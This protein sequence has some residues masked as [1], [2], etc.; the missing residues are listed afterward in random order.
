MTKN[1]RVITSESEPSELVSHES[2]D[3]QPNLSLI[4]TQTSDVGLSVPSLA[5]AAAIV[6][7]LEKIRIANGNRLRILTAPTDKA[8]DDGICRGLGLP[9]FHPM[10]VMLQSTIADIQVSEAMAVKVLEKEVKSHP[11]G[12]WIQKTK[13]VGLKQA[14]RLLSAIGDPY[15]NSST[16]QPRTVSSLWA[17]CGL[18][19]G[20]KRQKGVK[21]NWSSVAKTRALLIA[22]K[23][24]QVGAEHLR[25]VYYKRRAHTSITQPDWTK[26][27]SHNDAKR[28][29]AKEIL[30]LMWIEAARLHGVDVSNYKWE[31]KDGQ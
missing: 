3:T 29:L 18:A 12:P 6:D 16:G 30:K 22:D 28:I 15:M 13:G 27:H 17:Y 25:D 31:P 10:A 24:I 4:D 23:V 19:P 7:D 8:D 9:D 5:F 11:M 26:L 1:S 2:N 14:G 20:Q 21:S